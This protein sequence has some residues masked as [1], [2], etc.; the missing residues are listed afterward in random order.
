MQMVSYLRVSTKQQGA[1]GLGLEAQRAAVAAYAAS[2]KGEIIKEYIEVE[3]GRKT[4]TKRPQL[5]QAIPFAKRAKARLVVAK[6]DRLARNVVF[7][8]Q[9]IESGVDFAACDLPAANKLTLHIMSA[10]AE[11]EADMISARTKAALQA[12]KERGTLLGSA[13]PGHWDGRNDS[14]RR[15][16]ALGNARSAEARAIKSRDA[17]KDL[18]PLI[19]ELR[20]QGLSLPAIAANLNSDGH[21][22]RRNCLFTP[23]A[24]KRIIDHEA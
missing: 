17:Y 16:A 10:V 22:T 6:L 2:N 11:A 3:S 8:G 7:L 5:A 19:M 24:V 12:A 14:R 20:V 9:I 13:R 15:G 23:I 21:R 4:D 1:S 18:R